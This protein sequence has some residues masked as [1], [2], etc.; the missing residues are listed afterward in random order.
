MDI[1]KANLYCIHSPRVPTIYN[2]SGHE[3]IVQVYVLEQ[4]GKTTPRIVMTSE[5]FDLSEAKKV[6]V[7]VPGLGQPRDQNPHT[8]YAVFDTV[9]FSLEIIRLPYDI[10]KVA[11]AMKQEPD[12]PQMS[13]LRLRLFEGV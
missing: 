10:D 11:N 1:S 13:R 4:D 3:H 12:F 9:S 7:V 5:Q 2:F 6:M 8:G